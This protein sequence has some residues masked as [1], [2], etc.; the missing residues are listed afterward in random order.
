MAYGDGTIYK[1]GKIYWMKF[2]RDNQPVSM[3]C[4]TES[5]DV[6]RTKLRAEMRKSND[7]FI[8]ARHKRVTVSDL[9]D[10]AL[11]HWQA[12][13]KSDYHD[14][15][16][17]RWENHMKKP[18]GAVKAALFGTAH[19][20]AYRAK[21]VKDG[22]A[23]A[24]INRELQIVRQAFILGYDAEPPTVKRVP[25][26][27]LP[28]EDNAR[29][30][31]ATREQVEALRVAA[32][33]ESIEM[34]VMVEIAIVFGWRRSELL[35][36]RVKDVHLAD[37]TIRLEDSKNGEAREVPMPPAMKTLVEALVVG[38]KP[39]AH[40]WSDSE[41]TLMRVWDRVRKAAGCPDLLLHSLRR[42]SARSKRSAG[43]DASVIM[44]VQGWK[45]DSVFRRYAIVA[46]DDKREAFAKLEEYEKRQPLQN[47]YNPSEN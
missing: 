33:Q 12:A 30:Q 17:S 7:E 43:V 2:Y 19:M 31:F 41:T 47:S 21:R 3:S 22:A 6:A 5:K 40:L 20:D 23:S 4:K 29:K 28:K 38:R 34:R 13:G 18:F 24:T 27:K 26:F 42:T 36:L 45:T 46:I 32:G 1:R 14:V 44:A 39:E 25:R 35:Y 16:K 10:A 11:L 8:S 9:I 37:G 15:S